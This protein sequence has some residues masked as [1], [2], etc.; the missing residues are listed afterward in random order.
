MPAFPFPKELFPPD[1]FPPGLQ[2]SEESLDMLPP[3]VRELVETGQAS[4]LGL[5]FEASS[6]HLEPGIDSLFSL[7]MGSGNLPGVANTKSKR[8]SKQDGSVPNGAVPAH[9]D[10]EAMSEQLELLSACSEADLMGKLM[11]GELGLGDVGLGGGMGQMRDA[12]KYFGADELSES[13]SDSESEQSDPDDPRSK[14]G[15]AAQATGQGADSVMSKRVHSDTGTFGGVEQA[16]GN[17]QPTVLIEEF[18]EGASGFEAFRTEECGDR[19]LYS[20]FTCMPNI[21]CL[22]ECLCAFTESPT[23]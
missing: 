20:R 13:S 3:S 14:S 23:A 21:F 4:S 6:E 15:T 16:D 12:L 7:L 17:G 1:M 11:R 5:M 19:G 10:F 2:F 9:F 22:I 8:S 18:M